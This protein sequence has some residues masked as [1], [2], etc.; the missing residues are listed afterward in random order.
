MLLAKMQF[1]FENSEWLLFV[2]GGV[3]T[4]VVISIFAFVLTRKDKN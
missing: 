4:I 3:L 2:A 1:E